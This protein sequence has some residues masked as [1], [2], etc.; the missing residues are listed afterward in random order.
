MSLGPEEMKLA[1]KDFKTA[2]INMLKDL[3]GT[4]ETSRNKEHNVWGENVPWMDLTVLHFKAIKSRK[5]I[6]RETMETKLQRDLKKKK[7]TK[8]TSVTSEIV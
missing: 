8:N 7:N 2:I 3:K 4:N 1:N 6:A 5:K